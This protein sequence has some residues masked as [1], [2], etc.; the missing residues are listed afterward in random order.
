MSG[1]RHFVLQQQQQQL[2][3]CWTIHT[4]QRSVWWKISHENFF[5]YFW[6]QEQQ[7]Q[8]GVSELGN[9]LSVFRKLFAK[10][11]T[12]HGFCVLKTV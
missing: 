8:V 7:R 1:V 4:I 3:A 6:K 12:I 9:L 11:Q 2:S 5:I 10:L